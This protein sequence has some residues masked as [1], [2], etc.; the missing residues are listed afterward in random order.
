MIRDEENKMPGNFQ[1]ELAKWS[2]ECG[3]NLRLDLEI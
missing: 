2:F 3:F 1:E